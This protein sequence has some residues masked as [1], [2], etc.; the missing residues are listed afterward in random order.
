M[1]A[2]IDSH[3]ITRDDELLS[4]RRRIA[5][6]E[7]EVALYRQAASETWPQQLIAIEAALDGIAILDQSGAYTYM[8]RAHALVHGYQEP[9]DLLGQ[10]WNV[11]VPDDQISRFEQEYM[12]RLWRDGHWRGEVVSKRRDGSLHP[13][14]T[15]LTVL[16]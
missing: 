14:D 10:S 3:T 9:A 11:V 2:D 1:T 16:E 7:Q 15:S 8:N 4:L 12:P 13:T 5:E 6:L